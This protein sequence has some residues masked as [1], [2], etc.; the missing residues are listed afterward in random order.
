MSERA[1]HE[2]LAIAVLT[3]AALVAAR[4]WFTGVS[5][6]RDR[7]FH[8]VALRRLQDVILHGGDWRESQLAWPLENGVAQAD[9]LLGPALLALPLEVAG[10][11]PAHQHTFLQILAMITTGWATHRIAVAL[12][13][14]GP[15]TWI[16]AIGGGASTY[17]LSHG[18]HVNL[19]HHELGIGGALLLAHGLRDGRPGRAAAGAFL[20]AL[21]AHFG[22]YMGVHGVASAALVLLLGAAVGWRS[23]RAQAAGWI[24]LAAGAATFAPVAAVYREHART[25]EIQISPEELAAQSL[26][27]LTV[28]RPTV[29]VPLHVPEMPTGSV[30]W[31]PANPGYVLAALAL[32]GL[33]VAWRDRE[34]RREWLVVIGFTVATFLLALGPRLQIGGPTP[35]PGPYALF[36]DVLPVASSLRGPIR[37]LGLTMVGT[38][39]LAAAGA[40]ALAGAVSRP[41]LAWAA[42]FALV[43]AELPTDRQ[44]IVPADA[45]RPHPVYDRVVALRGG[46]ALYDVTRSADGCSPEQRINA[47]LDHQ[48]SVVGGTWSRSSGA[49]S[50]LNQLALSWPGPGADALFRRIRVRWVLVHPPFPELPEE[51]V[52]CE[53]VAEHLLCELTGEPPLLPAVDAVT[54]DPVGPAIGVRWASEP[55]APPPPPG[56]GP[57]P[58]APPPRDEAPRGGQHV[59][60]KAPPKRPPGAKGHGGRPISAT[61]DGEE[62]VSAPTPTWRV[63]SALRSPGAFEVFFDRPCDR[64]VVSEPGGTLLYAVPGSTGTWPR[65]PLGTR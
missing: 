63:L 13:G 49:T 31:D 61:C 52:R 43:A 33:V 36:V 30:A 37:F 46:G 44:E 12:L 4:P 3:A 22:V 53:A 5:G 39:V 64:P 45:I 15:H 32:A 21:S 54:T 50:I 28:L 35:I 38:S 6:H 27:P 60:G 2:A 58:G 10:V 40:R 59:E 47:I 41:A 57:R 56:G 26:D 20:A 14:Y 23:A 17:A 29:H 34:R 42:L 25:Y 24:G 65:E 62:L 1:R 19:V 7:L 8:S 11:D 16:A 9:W 48:R 55:G 18:P 51:G